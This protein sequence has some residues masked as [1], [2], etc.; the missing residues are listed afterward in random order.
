MENK[1]I[2]SNCAGDGSVDAAM[3]EAIGEV[4]WYVPLDVSRVEAL[5][6]QA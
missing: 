5:N 2:Q 1:A 4:R 6:S 3:A